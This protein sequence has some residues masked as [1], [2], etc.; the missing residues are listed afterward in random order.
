MS[1]LSWHF[2]IAFKFGERTEDII[3]AKNSNKK[4]A[5]EQEFRYNT[6]NIA[7]KPSLGDSCLGFFFFFVL[8]VVAF[9][10]SLSLASV[11]SCLP[12]FLQKHLT[13]GKRL[14]HVLKIAQLHLGSPQLLLKRS[15]LAWS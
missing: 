8:L 6:G 9:S 1:Y 15:I 10:L 3:C 7:V 5:A 2:T 12:G 11:L 14:C 13:G 4:V